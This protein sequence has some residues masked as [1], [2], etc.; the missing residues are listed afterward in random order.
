M[1][2]ADDGALI[3]ETREGAEEELGRWREALERVESEYNKD[4]VHVFEQRW[5]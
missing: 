5:S 2:F 4:R 3:N 1:L